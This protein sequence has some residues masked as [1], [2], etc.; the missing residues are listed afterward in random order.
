MERLCY[1]GVQ[2]KVYELSP[3]LPPNFAMTLKLLTI[4]LKTGDDDDYDDIGS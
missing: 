3:Y 1:A 4:F 2:V